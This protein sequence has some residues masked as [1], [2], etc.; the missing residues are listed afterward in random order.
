MSKK[1]TIGELSDLSGINKSTLRS[2]H[3]KNLIVPHKR[4]S[5]NNYRY[6]SEEQ[7]IEA[8]MIREMKRRGFYISDIKEILNTNSLSSIKNVI[9]K[10]IIFLEEEAKK[11]QEKI[12]YS[13]FSKK[14]ISSAIDNL[15]GN[16]KN[17]IIIEE[18]AEITILYQRVICSF[19]ANILFWERYNEL[20][21]LCR[22]LKVTP[23]G[24]FSAIF[25]GNYFNQFFFEEGD[26]EV[27]IPIEEKDEKGSNIRKIEG[28]L[29]A[30]II[31][32][33]WYG[34]LLETYIEIV[35]QIGKM[36][37]EIIGPSYEE[38]LV[39]FSYGISDDQCVTRI[40]F[41]VKPIEIE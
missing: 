40:S 41:P 37:Y 33:G 4:G 17:E 6:Y 18:V 23:N 3:K 10:K 38:Y 32:V 11:I 25:H 22:K 30:S 9:D 34:D 28:Y 20:M 24:P 14:L 39:E 19:N 13:K 36:G 21:L 35:K 8:I 2:Y 7:I 26:L 5:I 12:E 15:E 31:F 16:Y 29:R 1:Y 27:Y